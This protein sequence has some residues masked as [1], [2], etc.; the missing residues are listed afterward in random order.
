MKNKIS[1]HGV[2]FKKIDYVSIVCQ[3]MPF[4]VVQGGKFIVHLLHHFQPCKTL[5]L[6]RT[7]GVS[8]TVLVKN[9]DTDL[10]TGSK[11]SNCIIVHLLMTFKLSSKTI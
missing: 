9:S 4:H 3:V 11:K 10:S 1:S 7:K 6:V 5:I 2:N 8:K